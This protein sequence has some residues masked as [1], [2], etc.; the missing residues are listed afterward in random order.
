MFASVPS[1]PY[2]FTPDTSFFTSR[3]TVCINPLS[4]DGRKRLI[5]QIAGNILSPLET[6][7][8]HNSFLN[9]KRTSLITL[10]LFY[11]RHFYKKWIPLANI[12]LSK[13]KDVFGAPENVCGMYKKMWLKRILHSEI[14]SQRWMNMHFA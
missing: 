5:I 8:F 4:C 1:I 14:R 10:L 3:V 9:S 11:E 13:K 6:C 12:L 7:C 2:T